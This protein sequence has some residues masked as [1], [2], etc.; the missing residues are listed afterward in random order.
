HDQIGRPDEQVRA[1]PAAVC[2]R[3]AVGRLD[4]GKGDDVDREDAHH[5]DAANDVERDDPISRC[6]C[7]A[8]PPALD[9]SIRYSRGTWISP[10]ATKVTAPPTE[11]AVTVPASTMALASSRLDRP[12]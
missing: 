1:V 4:H 11:T 8:M 12:I 10:C 5:G 7:H 9:Y 2:R 6:R 3:I